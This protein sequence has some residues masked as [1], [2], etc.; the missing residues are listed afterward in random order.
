MKEI[1]IKF[2]VTSD[3]HS[4]KYLSL[5]EKSMAE[6]DDLDLFLFVGDMILKGDIKQYDKILNIVRNGFEGPIFAVFGNE[7]YDDLH[8]KIREKYSEIDF[9]DDEK[10]IIK[11]KGIDI[12]IVGTTGS[13]DELTWWQ[14]KNRPKNVEIYNKR[15]EKIDELISQLHARIKIFMSHYALTYESMKGENLSS[16]PQL[17]SKRYEDIIRKYELDYVFHGHVHRGLSSIKLGNTSIFNVSIPKFKKIKV[18]DSK[19]QI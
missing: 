18:I 7:E 8:Q 9:L 19:I 6:I 10:R 12:G 13:L 5:F 16:Y 11:I 14:S 3:V 15:I 4:P 2:A 17:G 1:Q